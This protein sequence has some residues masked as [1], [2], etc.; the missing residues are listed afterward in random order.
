MTS[1]GQIPYD[2]RMVL[3][4]KN[5]EID[6]PNSSAT[7]IAPDSAGMRAI[8]RILMCNNIA[9]PC[10]LIVDGQLLSEFLG[11]HA[12]T[13]TLRRFTGDPEWSAAIRALV[14]LSVRP[15]LPCDSSPSGVMSQIT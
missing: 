1:L 5:W 4:G 8:A 11:S 6:I 10:A 13:N 3:N 9:C 14:K 2:A 7:L 12:I 15:A